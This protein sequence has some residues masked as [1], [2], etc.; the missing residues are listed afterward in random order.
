M[1]K[2]LAQELISKLDG[3]EKRLGKIADALSLFKV[4]SM[5]FVIAYLIVAVGTYLNS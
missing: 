3:I 5:A 2:E 1:E 4:M